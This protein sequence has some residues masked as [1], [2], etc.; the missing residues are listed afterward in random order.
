MSGKCRLQIQVHSILTPINQSKTLAAGVC[1]QIRIICGRNRSVWHQ[2][3]AQLAGFPSDGAAS[4]SS[5]AVSEPLKIHV[6]LM[7]SLSQFPAFK[8]DVRGKKE[9]DIY[10]A[11]TWFCQSCAER[12]RLARGG[13]R[14]S[15]T[16][17]NPPPPRLMSH[18][19]L[20]KR[21]SGSKW[22]P[23]SH[24]WRRSKKYLYILGG[25]ALA[26]AQ[27]RSSAEARPACQTFRDTLIVRRYSQ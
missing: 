16:R 6:G 11:C 23:K 13:E 24:R 5:L 10:S 21:S 22:L 1:A 8:G 14:C 17:Q 2:L 27:L 4:V 20:L 3:W 25:G 12:W 18:Q 9:G 19:W 26:S 15:G 7:Q